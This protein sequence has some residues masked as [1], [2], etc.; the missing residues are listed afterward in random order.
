VK[1]ILE[2]IPDTKGSFFGIGK[3]N[4]EN[5]V[6]FDQLFLVQEGQEA[7]WFSWE[8]DLSIGYHLISDAR[9]TGLSSTICFKSKERKFV[10]VAVLQGK[11]RLF[12]ADALT[13]EISEIPFDFNVVFF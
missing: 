12:T 3:R 13:H 7:Q 2:L 9:R 1:S 11:Q 8:A 10:F 4:N 5:S 6:D